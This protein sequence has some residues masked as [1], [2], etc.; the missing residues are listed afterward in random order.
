MD[1]L[2]AVLKAGG[3]DFSNVVKTNIY[4]TDMSLFPR[5]NEVYKTYF[6]SDPP[7]RTT[8]GVTALPGEPPIEIA[9]V[10]SKSKKP[11]Q[12]IVRPEGDSDPIR[13]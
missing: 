1:N 10:A 2:G 12:S 4:L 3:M 13:F 8:V 5:M 7:A 11:G 9:F 6:K